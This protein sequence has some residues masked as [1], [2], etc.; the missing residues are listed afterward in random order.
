[1][2]LHKYTKVGAPIMPPC[3]IPHIFINYDKVSAH[4]MAPCL[5]PHTLIWWI[6]LNKMNLMC[7]PA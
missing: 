6:I 7:H 3:L 4:I 5:I 2:Y 1:M